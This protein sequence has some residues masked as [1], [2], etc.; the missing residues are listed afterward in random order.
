MHRNFAKYYT[1]RLYWYHFFYH[2]I[3]C[4]ILSILLIHNLFYSISDL[5]CSRPSCSDAPEGESVNCLPPLI[6]INV[7]VHLFLHIHRHFMNKTPSPL[8]F[9][10][11]CWKILLDPDTFLEDDDPVKAAG[12]LIWA[13]AVMVFCKAFPTTWELLW[14]FVFSELVFSPFCTAS[15]VISLNIC[16]V[17]PHV[18]IRPVRFESV[19]PPYYRLLEYPLMQLHYLRDFSTRPSYCQF[20]NP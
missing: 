17:K 4:Y 3:Y 11:V 8:N 10:P 13:L 12:D 6:F 16:L 5:L 9:H 14:P 2:T 19:P 7:L 15:A 18:P 1:A 20:L